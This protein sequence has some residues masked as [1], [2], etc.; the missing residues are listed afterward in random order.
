MRDWVNYLVQEQNTYYFKFYNEVISILTIMIVLL[1]VLSCFFV[2]TSI[3]FDFTFIS[4][5]TKINLYNAS[6]IAVVIILILLGYLILIK[7]PSLRKYT[8]GIIESESIIIRSILIDG[9][10]DLDCILRR[11]K[12]IWE[13]IESERKKKNKGW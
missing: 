10:T 12:D 7:I 4:E 6:W 13:K 8:N 5:D 11:Y 9:E 3:Q 2:L 1:T